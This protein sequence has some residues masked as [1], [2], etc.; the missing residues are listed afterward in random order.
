MAHTPGPWLIQNTT[1]Y[2]LMHD[3]YKKDVEQ[4]R[5]RFYASVQ[6][7]RECTEEEATAN[8]RL[9]AAAPELL[10]FAKEW[11]SRQGTDANYMTAKA[12]AAI[13]KAE[14]GL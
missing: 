1:V 3:S 7:D 14:G 8:A 9:I 4:F 2:A 12:K 6:K 10:E 11:L 5:N 13:E